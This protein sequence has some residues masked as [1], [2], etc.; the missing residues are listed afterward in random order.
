MYNFAF[1]ALLSE[2][3]NFVEELP[4]SSVVLDLFFQKN[5]NQVKGK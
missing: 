3:G 2:M 1:V 5:Q 4:C